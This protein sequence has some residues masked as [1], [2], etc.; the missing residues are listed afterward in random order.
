MEMVWEWMVGHDASDYRFE[1]NASALF[2]G[3]FLPIDDAV[4]GFLTNKL[5]SSRKQ[6]L[7]WV[8]NVLSHAEADFVF[9]YQDFVVLFLDQC[10]RTG[11]PARRKGIEAL[12]RASLSGVRTGRPGEPMPRD[13]D[14]SK[15][16]AEILARLPKQSGAYELY[17][18]LQRDAD[19]NIEQA[20]QEAEFFDDD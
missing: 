16:A 2:E 20:R 15:Q 19:R 11:R 4:I 12:F 9:E 8:A 14:T 6:D 1:Y 7:R 17:T 3:A 10:D 13:I 18:W 5:K